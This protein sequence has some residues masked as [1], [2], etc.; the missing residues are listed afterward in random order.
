[1]VDRLARYANPPKPWTKPI[2]VDDVPGKPIAGKP[3]HWGYHLLL[4]ISDCNHDIDDPKK[5]E[6]FI[7]DLVKALK[8]KTIGDPMVV[9]VEG[10]DGRGVTAVQIITTSTITFHG[11]NDKWSV[12]LDVFSCKEFEPETAIGLVK[13]YFAPKH[14]GKL[15]LHR[16]AGRWPEK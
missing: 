13:Q 4:D 1:M 14:I 12:Y 16:D 7:A 5:V 11:D 6:S 10:E 2:E 3:K 9:K 15:W 8:M